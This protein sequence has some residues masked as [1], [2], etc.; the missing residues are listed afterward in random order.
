MR[1]RRRL[2]SAHFDINF[3]IDSDIDVDNDLDAGWT[4][5]T[6]PVRHGLDDFAVVRAPTTDSAFRLRSFL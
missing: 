3:Y 1:G 4:I 5:F 2:G 6:P